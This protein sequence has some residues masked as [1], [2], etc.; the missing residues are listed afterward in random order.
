MGPVPV[1]LNGDRPPLCTA[2]TRGH[3]GPLEPGAGEVVAQAAAG[4]LERA[5]SGGDGEAEGARGVGGAEAEHVTE[6]ERGVLA[7]GQVTHRGEQREL[8]GFPREYDGV[9]LRVPRRRELD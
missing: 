2:G 9:R 4:A 7:R 1:Y 6:Y 8:D 3:R 5:G